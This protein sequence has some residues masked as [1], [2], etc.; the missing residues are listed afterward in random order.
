MTASIWG[1][2]AS[3]SGKWKSSPSRGAPLS[4]PTVRRRTPACGT[5]KHSPN[6]PA[7]F[8]RS[9]AQRPEVDWRGIAGFR[10]VL[11]H[12]YR[13]ANLE[14]VWIILQR[15]LPVLKAAVDALLLEH[16]LGLWACDAA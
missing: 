1:T 11:V 9:C 13:G 12:D 3:A 14:R 15:D 5:R 2:C 6:P 4:S 16:P 10:N 8:H 7:G